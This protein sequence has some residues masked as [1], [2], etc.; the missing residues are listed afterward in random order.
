MTRLWLTVAKSIHCAMPARLLNPAARA[1]LHL[2]GSAP[3]P[4]YRPR[5]L[6]IRFW[7][8][9]RT[10]PDGC[11]EWQ[12]G[13]ARFGHGL[14]HTGPGAR[15]SQA[16]RVSWELNVGP[17][18]PGACVLHR[19]DNPPCVNPAHLFLGTKHD[20][21]RDMVAKGRAWWQQDREGV[22]VP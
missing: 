11:W 5:P 21:I 19:C 16:H 12:G 8:K 2:E 14:I 9:V 3:M 7:E 6:Y 10:Q 13:R 20:N 1:S 17:V 15:L 22:Q 4:N 18:P